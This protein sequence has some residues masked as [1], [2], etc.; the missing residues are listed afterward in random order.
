MVRH[1]YLELFAD[2]RAW[3]RRAQ[4]LAER[5]YEFSE[6]LVDVIGVTDLGA[7]F[8]GRLTYHAS[9]HLLRDLGV[10]R[11]PAALLSAVQ[12]A[13]LRELPAGEECCGFGGVFSV[14]HPELSDAMLLRKITHL[15]ES[16]ADTLVACDAGCLTHIN[17]GL[18][19]MG[20]APC[21]VHIAQVLDGSIYAP[22]GRVQTSADGA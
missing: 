20:K 4:A 18:R 11:P 19:R 3:L 8:N 5:T 17:G 10:R 9:C 21:G 16:G 1:G 14:E 2:D 22:P 6:Y 15:E 12:G 13:E 7:R